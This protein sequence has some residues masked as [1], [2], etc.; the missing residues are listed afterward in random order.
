MATLIKEPFD[1]QNWF[2]EVKWDGYRTIALVDNGEVI[3]YSR[4][5]KTF[6]KK[7]AEIAKSLSD[8]TGQFIFD[9]EIVALDNNGVPIFQF[10]QN[11]ERF[12]EGHLYY[13]VFDLLF[14]D[15]LNLENSPFD[16]RRH[17]LENIPLPS[18]IRLS[19]AIR[20]N[21]KNF[22]QEIRSKGLEGMVAKKADSLYSPGVRSKSWLKIKTDNEQEA[23]IGGFTEPR[24]GR[25]G[26]GSLLL[27]VYSN[28][29]LIYIGAVGAGFD[30]NFLRGFRIKL[31]KIRIDHSPFINPPKR[32]DL[33]FVEAK[34]VCM[35]KFREWTSEGVV[36]QPVFLGIREDKEPR[37][38]IK[39][40]PET[41]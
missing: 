16:E 38:V 21:G 35:I 20:K 28:N 17:N 29:K 6:N 7:F 4:N 9:G 3:L 24:G 36:R 40:R 18:N 37:E 33:S 22:F 30:D 2:F 34:Y 1:D 31:D 39:E 8:L 11:Y 25:P 26:F 13:Y 15:G 12:K 27:G 5:K 23:V 10:L 41:R 19:A 32:S 14:R